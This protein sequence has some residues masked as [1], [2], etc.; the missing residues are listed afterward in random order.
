MKDHSLPQTWPIAASLV[1]GSTEDSQK[2]MVTEVSGVCLLTDTKQQT[3]HF[4]EGG[5]GF[6]QAGFF[7]RGAADK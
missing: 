7:K 6:I 2:L 4:L 5:V 3:L 1:L